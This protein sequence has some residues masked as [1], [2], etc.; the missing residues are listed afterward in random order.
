MNP[1]LHVHIYKD[2]DGITHSPCSLLYDGL[3]VYQDR[4][5]VQYYYN[6]LMKGDP[7]V[8]VQLGIN[9]CRLI[10]KIE[11]KELSIFKSSQYGCYYY[12]G[13]II[14]SFREILNRKTPPIPSTC[15]ARSLRSLI[16]SMTED[17]I[18]M[19]MD[20]LTATLMYYEECDDERYSEIVVHDIVF[21]ERYPKCLYTL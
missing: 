1:A 4:P 12:A 7:R 8:D 18:S 17:T 9:A 21:E 6:A 15:S 14:D 20:M 11:V 2:A 3:L 19:F 5:T 13:T 16:P 10:T